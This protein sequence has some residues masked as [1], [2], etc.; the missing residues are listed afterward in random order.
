MSVSIAGF[1]RQCC[2]AEVRGGEDQ[3]SY[4]KRFAGLMYFSNVE[5]CT[6]HTVTRKNFLLKND[7]PVPSLTEHNLTKDEFFVS[8]VI[9]TIFQAEKI[10]VLLYIN[11]NTIFFNH[12]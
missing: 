5:I 9:F 1:V 12:S 4:V 7:F 10:F 2:F 6:D 8:L 3:I 11:K